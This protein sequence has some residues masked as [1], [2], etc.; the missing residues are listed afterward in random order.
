MSDCVRIT[1]KEQKIAR[2]RADK[3]LRNVQSII[4][5]DG[6]RFTWRI[7]GSGCWGTMIKDSEEKYDLDYQILLT[8]NSKCIQE[9]TPPKEIK[10]V[11]YQ[12]FSSSKNHD[13]KIA[14]STTAITLT[15]SIES[16]K[17]FSIDFV[18]IRPDSDEIIR[19]NGQDHYTWNK[20]PHNFTKTYSTFKNANP[21][22]K[23]EIVDKTIKRKCLEKKKPENE[24]VSSSVIFIEEINKH[25][26]N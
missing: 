8:N 19:R 6:Y 17:H 7:V 23:K 3:I 9:E 1:K 10:D 14:N 21:E 26:K 5:G 15:N 2:T 22:L 11:F 20:L 18:I 16:G 12:A 4:R 25:V 24:R 13:E